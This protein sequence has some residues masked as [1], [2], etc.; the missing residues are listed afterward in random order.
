MS[1]T[2]QPESP[3]PPGV[4]SGADRDAAPTVLPREIW[5]P[6]QAEHAARVD[7]LTGGHRTRARAGVAHPVEDFLFSYYSLRPAQ[8]RRWHPGPGVALADAP[9]RAEWKF[10]RVLQA[11][12]TVVL[13]LPGFAAARRSQLAFTRRLLAATAAR[14]GQFGC[15][16]LHEWAMV[17]RQGPQ[18]RHQQ[19]PLRLGQDDTD[20]VVRDHPVKCTHFDAFRFFTPPARPLNA[21]Q[22]DR[23]SQLGTEQPGCLHAAMD[24]YKW[25]YKLIPAVP[26]ALLLDTF[27]FAGR[28]REL[29]MRASPYDLT[30][31]GYSPVRIETAEGK[32]EYV[33]AQRGIAA[34]AAAL[35]SRLLSLVTGIEQA[36][37]ESI[38]D[39]HPGP[40]SNPPGT[41]RHR[42]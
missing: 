42:S 3:P 4:W 14:P 2:T 19:W 11:P 6:T 5:W 26:S 20:Q 35:R 17:Y 12:D 9:E 24:V 31:L 22:L 10:H 38:S 15:F 25:A 8:L 37:A 40:G 32:A 39:P 29:D 30:D 41:A 21:Q 34:S 1:T 16:G 7:E 18:R 33:T 23:D 36:A 13:D 27:L 28:V